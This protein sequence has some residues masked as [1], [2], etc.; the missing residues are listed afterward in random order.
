MTAKAPDAVTLVGRLVRLRPLVAADA[1]A[2]WSGCGSDE[3][4]RWVWP[5]R[6]S[7]AADMQRFVDRAVAEAESGVRLPF[8]QE[9][10]GTGEPVGTTSLLDIDPDNGRVEI[11]WTVLSPSVWGTGVNVEAKLLLMAYAFDDLGMERVCWKTDHLNARSQ[12][13]IAALGATREGV[14]RHHMRRADG[15]W[16]DSVYFS[17]LRDEWP[18]VQGRLRDRLPPGA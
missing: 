15:S 13:A 6:M 12:V 14:L 9:R 8:V 5:Y 16:R 7:E 2:L 3:A 10:A 4:F 18:Q 17:V 11:G 1:A